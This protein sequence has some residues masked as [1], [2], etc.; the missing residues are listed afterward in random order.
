MP[1]PLEKYSKALLSAASV[2]PHPCFEGLSNKQHSLA[3]L[4]NLR[5]A[6]DPSETSHNDLEELPRHCNGGNDLH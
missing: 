1:G 3:E 5:A 6:K 4:R 2:T